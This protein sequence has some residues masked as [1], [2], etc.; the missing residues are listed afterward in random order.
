MLGIY[1]PVEIKSW[2]SVDF[3][4]SRPTV[5]GRTAREFAGI[6]FYIIYILCKEF[7]GIDIFKLEYLTKSLN[8][9]KWWQRISEDQ[10]MKKVK[11]FIVCCSSHCTFTS[12]VNCPSSCFYFYA[13]RRNLF[14]NSA[15][16]RRVEIESQKKLSF[17]TCCLFL[18]FSNCYT[19]MFKVMKVDVKW[20]YA[21]MRDREKIRPSNIRDLS[22]SQ[23]TSFVWFSVIYQLCVC[24]IF[25]RFVPIRIRFHF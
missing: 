23:P 18:L 12:F 17:Y 8:P 11:R 1:T 7:S 14:Q 10:H 24:N 9:K 16:M 20:L 4:I 15:H 25:I 19:H 5:A 2:R 22:K 21:K 6:F 13:N 3:V